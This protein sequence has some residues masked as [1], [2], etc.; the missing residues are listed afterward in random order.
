MISI[1]QVQFKVEIGHVADRLALFQFHRS[2]SRIR[3]TRRTIPL[4]PISIPQVQFKVKNR[5]TLYLRL[6]I[7][8]PQVQFKD[9]RLPF[10]LLHIVHFNST[11]PIQGGLGKRLRRR[12]RI[13]I[14]QVQFKDIGKKLLR[15]RVSYF[16]SIG[17]IQGSLHA[18]FGLV[19]GKFQFHRSNSRT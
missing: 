15:R 9:F 6:L 2:N 12:G 1:P 8:I 7:S 13:S 14:P 19:T 11:G 16:N 17:P 10:F 5:N 18:R 4:P 3:L